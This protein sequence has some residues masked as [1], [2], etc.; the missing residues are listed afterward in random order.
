[1]KES[2]IVIMAKSPES[3]DVKTRLSPILDAEERRKLYTELLDG[4]V[5]R[6]GN[7][8]GADTLIAY[9]PAGAGDFFRERYGMPCF[10]QEGDDLGQR[11]SNA[12][13]HMLGRGYRS[14][15]IV[16]SDIPGLASGIAESALTALKKADMAI[17]PST[18]GGYYLIG[19]NDPL[20]ELFQDIPWSTA[21][22][23]K[24][25]VSKARQ[26]GM[27]LEIM[28]ILDDIDTPEDLKRLG[29]L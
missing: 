5:E 29:L 14:V 16:G 9:T 1:M 17:G 6:L 4:T 2:A 20:P 23:L 15:V 26:M 12:L 21:E 8:K 19:L 7:V 24:S 22:V 28:E 25:T 3:G 10:G 13:R 27:S 11:L 18:D